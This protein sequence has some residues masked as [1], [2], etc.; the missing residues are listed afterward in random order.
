[1]RGFFTNPLLSDGFKRLWA[2]PRTSSHVIAT[3]C[4][5]AVG[6][7]RLAADNLRD[8]V[9]INRFRS[10]HAEALAGLFGQVPALCAQAGMSHWKRSRGTA[11]EFNRRSSDQTT[12][13]DGSQGAKPVEEGLSVTPLLLL[14]DWRC[15][16][17]YPAATR[18]TA[19]GRGNKGHGDG[20]A[21]RGCGW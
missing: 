3:S 10:A 8:H 18:G 21:V 20:L 7:A 17:W 4:P 16:A 9:T 12:K 13:R 11:H 19:K 1:M 14:P 2:W 5:D 6:S 15:P